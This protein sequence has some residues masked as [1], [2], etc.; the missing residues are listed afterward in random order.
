MFLLINFKI[1]RMYMYLLN[2]N[3]K[4]ICYWSME[5][6]L[7]GFIYFNLCDK[8]EGVVNIL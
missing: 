7:V 2:N 1:I 5:K 8:N 3:I 4:L 6:F